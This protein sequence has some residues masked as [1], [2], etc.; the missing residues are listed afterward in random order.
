[1][2]PVNGEPQTYVTHFV[3]TWKTRIKSKIAFNL[4]R[5]LI[6]FFDGDTKKGSIVAVGTF[7]SG[8]FA[9]GYCSTNKLF[10]NGVVVEEKSGE[11]LPTAAK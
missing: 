4:R 11:C 3:R 8:L 9:W 6:C 5:G 10:E 2:K 1:M 7:Q